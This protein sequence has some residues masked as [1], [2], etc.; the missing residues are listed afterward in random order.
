MLFSIITINYNNANGLERT[1]KSVIDQTFKEFEFIIID[2]GSTD[3]GKEI[4]EKYSDNISYWVSEKD[5]GIWNAQNKGMK[6]AK[7]DYMLFLN[8]GD[9]LI[10]QNILEK[11]LPNLNAT[12]IIYGDILVEEKNN[13]RW[14]KKYSKPITFSYFFD[15]TLPHPASFI[16]RKILEKAG[17]KYDESLLISSD[18]KFFLDAVCKHDASIKYLNQTVATFDKTGLSTL[19]ENKKII[20]EERKRVFEKDYFRYFE[21]IY[22]IKEQYHTIINSRAM[23][24][25]LTVKHF[26]KPSL[27]LR[28]KP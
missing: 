22:E 18:W 25:Y 15:D 13:K 27:K 26:F 21:D 28:L 19:P 4:I 6:I 1:I 7:G 8:S 16:S 23:K 20:L 17:F 3:G 24:W 5:S 9:C 10:D 11:V 14:I 12:D 2:G